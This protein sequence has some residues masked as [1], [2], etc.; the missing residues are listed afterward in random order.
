MKRLVK[1]S[2]PLI[3]A[4][5]A[6]GAVDLQTVYE[7]ALAQDPIM[8]QAEALHMATRETKTQAILDMV[9]L[10]TNIS[11]TWNGRNS[12]N[13]ATPILGNLALQVNLFSWDKWIALKQA[14]AVVAQGEANYAAARQEQISRV[15]LRVFRGAGGEGHPGRSGQRA[16]VRDAPARA[17]RAAL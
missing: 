4:C 10:D 3:A 16:A 14:N 17:G 9:P 6:A 1:L 8:Q 5:G 2:L 12:D 7:Q 13:A 11:Q 15:A